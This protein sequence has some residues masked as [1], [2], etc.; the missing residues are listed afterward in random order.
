MLRQHQRSFLPS[1]YLYLHLLLLDPI[2]HHPASEQVYKPLRNVKQMMQK[3]GAAKEMPT[4]Q[5]PSFKVCTGWSPKLGGINMRFLLILAISWFRQAW[6]RELKYHNLA[7]CIQA[8]RASLP[9]VSQRAPQPAPQPIRQSA[10]QV[11]EYYH[12]KPCNA[13]FSSIA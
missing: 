9:Q 6:F 1:R 10:C 13:S 4:S 8:I 5:H 2:S 11:P 3:L 7:R 12:C